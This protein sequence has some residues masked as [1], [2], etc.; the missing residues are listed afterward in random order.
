VSN[1]TEGIKL[2]K[3]LFEWWGKAGMHTHKWMLN[4]LK[5]LEAIPQQ[6]RATEMSLDSDKSLPVKTLG[7]L[8]LANDDVFTFKSQTSERLI[9][10]TKLS[11]LKLIATLFDLLGFLSP[12][13]VRAKIIMQ[14]ITIGGLDW[15]DILPEEITAK[16]MSLLSVLTVLTKVRVPIGWRGHYMCLLMHLRMLMEQ[17]FT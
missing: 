13:I 9:T 15:D 6:Y 10:P 16:V 4:S 3:E 14:Q 1:E 2:Y 11:F 5:V 17:L 7:I 8:W 12:Y